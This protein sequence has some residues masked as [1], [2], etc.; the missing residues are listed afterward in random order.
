MIKGRTFSFNRFVLGLFAVALL[1]TSA[2][3]FSISYIGSLSIA[4]RELRRFAEKE[5]TLAN[6]VFA[7]SLSRLDTFLRSLAENRAL[8]MAVRTGDTSALKEVLEETARHP[9]GG[10]LEL[11]FIDREG[12]P[13]WVDAGFSLFDITGI[14]PAAQRAIMPT[15]IWQMHSGFLNGELTLL[16]AESIP[17]VDAGD[18]RV[19]GHVVGGF[20]LNDSIS[21][22]GD[23]SHVLD[24]ESLAIVSHDKIIAAVG[25]IRQAV[26]PDRIANALVEQNHTLIGDRLYIRSALRAD[27]SG[28]PTYVLTGRQGETIKNIHSTYKDLFA[29]FLLYVIAGSLLAAYALHRVTSPALQRLMSYAK[30]VRQS[31]PDMTYHPGKVKEFNKLGTALQDAFRDLKETDAQFRGLIDGSMHGVSIIANHKILYVNDALL[32][33]LG[34]ESADARNEL[35][36]A[37]GLTLFAPEEHQRLLSYYK[38]RRA[39]VSV[40]SVYEAR[41]LCKDGSRL[42]AELHVRPILWHR[43]TAFYVTI[44]DISERKRQEELI[45]RQANFDSLTG[46]ANR[47]LFRDRL[48]QSVARAQWGGGLVALLFLDLD[49]FKNVNDSLGHNAGDELIKA[50]ATRITAVLDDND[51]VARLGGDEFGIILTEVRSVWDAEL[52]TARILKAVAKPVLV[53]SGLEVFTTAS[54]GVTV[55][56]NDG[57]NDETLLRQADTAMY[58]AK[59]DGGNKL[60][61][62]SGQMNDHIARTMEIEGALRRTLEKKG[63][64]L[65]YQPVVDVE[66]NTILGCE[67]LVRWN[68]AETGSYSPAEFIP[69]AED[70]GLIVPLGAWVLEEACRFHQECVARGL[71]LP[72]ISVNVSPRQCRDDNFVDLVRGTLASTGM[73]AESL[74]LEITENV[75]FDETASDPIETLHAMKNLGVRLSLD[76]FGTG[77]SSLSNLKRFPIDTLKIDR[78]FVRDLET[79]SNDRALIEAIVVMAA[80]LDIKV[81]AEGAESEGQCRLLQSL[82]CT[83]IQ[84]YYLGRPMPGED[85][86]DL[87]NRGVEKRALMGGIA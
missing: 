36:G 86:I 2:A 83:S 51:S 10:R 53:G 60:R 4:D 16:A 58:H 55:S 39:G 75:M 66:L 52:R 78:T 20:V 64:S 71:T 61:F 8:Q 46:L 43:E 37:A 76:D 23:L 54:I 68:D 62:F 59:A 82:G 13:D 1:T 26:D 27:V 48:V 29:P 5:S 14:L 21:L 19:L 44:A 50:T 65:H 17:I 45:I 38:A 77:Y 80:R 31:G 49:R 70:T 32:D 87:L 12:T 11:L 3:L 30:Q 72:M 74:H 56:P 18:G 79:N 25:D 84:G 7:Q 47:N 34:Y 22:L 33:I 69:I 85:F 28:V 35:I 67:A 24:A 57:D 81:I 63:L 9:M 42:W 6:L 40:P 41:G 73:P 15:G